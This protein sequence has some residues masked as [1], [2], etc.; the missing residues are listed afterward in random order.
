MIRILERRKEGRRSKHN[1]VR[2]KKTFILKA[3]SLTSTENCQFD[4]LDNRERENGK[5][6][7]S[8]LVKATIIYPGKTSDVV[9][10]A[11]YIFPFSKMQE[12]RRQ[13]L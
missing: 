7:N 9:V 1:A 12:K 13:D 2:G 6:T 5:P 11:F 10:F 3:T 8:A 4:K